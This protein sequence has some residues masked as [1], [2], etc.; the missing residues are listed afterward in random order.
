VP[1]FI[2]Y[3]CSILTIFAGCYVYY[4]VEF[5]DV[6]DAYGGLSFVF[7]PPWQIVLL[8]GIFLICKAI[9]AVI[10]KVERKRYSGN[11]AG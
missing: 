10:R 6:D 5:I 7:L 1:R 9:E 2:F 4:H 8:G 11:V 3:F